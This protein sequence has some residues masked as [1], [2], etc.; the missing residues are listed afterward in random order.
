MWT[1]ID[2]IHTLYENNVVAHNTMGGISHEISYDAIIRNNTL[3]GNGADDPRSWWW[4]NEINIQ[5]SQHVDVYGN[6]VDMT[7]GGNGIVLI[8]QNRPSRSRGRYRSVWPPCYH[9]KQYPRQRH[10]RP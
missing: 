1:D 7:G 10:R 4:G 9:R 5:N 3:I 2:N 8:Q 6:R